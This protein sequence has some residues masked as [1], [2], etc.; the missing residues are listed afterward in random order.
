MVELSSS[1]TA[2][3]KSKRQRLEAPAGNNAEAKASNIDLSSEHPNELLESQVRYL[4][5]LNRSQD[6]SCLLSIISTCD[7]SNPCRQR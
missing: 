4:D 3:E 6:V 7:E 1:P 2:E 5:L